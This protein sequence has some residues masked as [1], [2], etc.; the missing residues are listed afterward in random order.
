MLV[1]RRHPDVV[2]GAESLAESGTIIASDTEIAISGAAIAGEAGVVGDNPKYAWSIEAMVSLTANSDAGP[3]V[4]NYLHSDR[5]NFRFDE[6][7]TEW[8]GAMVGPDEWEPRPPQ[9]FVKARG[10]QKD[11]GPQN[12]EPTDSFLSTAVSGDDL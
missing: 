1:I 3:G 5:T 6:L 8:T 10:S 9:D 11:K 4:S 2:E 7:K 12:P